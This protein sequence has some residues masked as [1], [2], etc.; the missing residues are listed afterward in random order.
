M[1]LA[2]VPEILLT[3]WEVDDRAAQDFF[4]TFY[5][6]RNSA[7]T[8][9]AAVKSARLRLLQEFKHPYF[10]SGFTLNGFARR[11]KNSLYMM[12]R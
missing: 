11:P 9:S 3:S 4:E 2:D 8:S 1:M 7:L 5:S 12:S 10:W 6:I